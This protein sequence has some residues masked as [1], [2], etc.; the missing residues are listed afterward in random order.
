[1]ITC[2]NNNLIIAKAEELHRLATRY[3]ITCE[4]ASKFLETFTFLTNSSIEP[5]SIMD[6]AKIEACKVLYEELIE[7]ANILEQQ[8]NTITRR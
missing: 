5:C 1:M 6:K 3:K 4:Q 7:E 8:I 2:K